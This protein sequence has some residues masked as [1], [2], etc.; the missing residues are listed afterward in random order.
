MK[1]IIRK[2]Q[3][4]KQWILSIVG[5][6]ANK[7]RYYIMFCETSFRLQV[8]KRFFYSLNVGDSVELDAILDEFQDRLRLPNWIINKKEVLET[9]KDEANLDR[10]KKFQK[11]MIIKYRSIDYDLW[12]MVE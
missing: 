11:N 3:E 8:S 4:F 12:L 10:V 5:K 6:W 2:L 1:T 7:R 9:M